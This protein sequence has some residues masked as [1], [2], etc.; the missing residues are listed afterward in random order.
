L[1]YCGDFPEE[2][3]MISVFKLWRVGN[4][5]LVEIHTKL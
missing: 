1:V 4:F 3:Y 2:D 5:K